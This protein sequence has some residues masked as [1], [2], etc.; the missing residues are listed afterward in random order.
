MQARR[1]IAAVLLLVC[2]TLTAQ[3]TRSSSSGAYTASQANAGERIDFDKC[4]ACHLFPRDRTRVVSASAFE[5]ARAN[6]N[7]TLQTMQSGD[8]R[9]E[10][11]SFGGAAETYATRGE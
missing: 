11:I 4:A 5:C 7:G 1:L 2:A 6:G 3:H 9:G 10:F 8:G